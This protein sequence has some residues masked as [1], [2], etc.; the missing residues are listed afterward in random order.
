MNIRKFT[1]VGAGTMGHGI[2]EL[3]ALAGYEVWLNDVNDDILKNALERIKWSLNKLHEKGQIKGVDEVIS[4]IRITSNLAEAVKDTDFLVEAVL[5][6]INVKREIFSK[7]DE[8]ASKDAV[9]ATNTSSLP[10][11]E[12]A[13]STK[14]PGRVLG[15]HFFNPPVLM[16]LVEVIRG[17]YT[18]DKVV[19]EAISIVERMGKT[20]II[21][22]K[23]IP[24][25][26]V[27]RLLFRLF[28]ISCLLVEGGK[29]SITDVD[30]TAIYELGF[31]MGV[32]ILEDYTGIDIGYLVGKAMIERG[33]KA[34]E[35]RMLEEKFS[36]REF[37][38]KSGK[39]FYSYPQPGKFVVPEIPK[40]SKVNGLTLI[41]PVINEASYLLRENISSKEDIDKGCKLGLGW[42]RGIFEYA[43]EYGIDKV[44]ATLDYLYNETNM[45]QFKP[46]P[47]L[48]EMMKTGKLG[49]KTGEGFYKYGE[50][51]T[52]G[53]LTIRVEEPLGWIILDKRDGINT[54]DRELISDLSKA[55]DIMEDD[56]RVRVIL[57][58]GNG[59]AFSVGVDVKEFLNLTPF[60]AM[61]ASRRLQELFNKIQFLAKPVIAVIHGYALGG[62]L[63]LAM[64]CD[65]RVAS[66]DAHLGQPEINLGLIPGAGGS[67]RLPRLAKNKG[68]YLV[69][70]GEIIEAEEAFRVGLVDF[71]AEPEKLEDEA[72]KIALKL[73]EKSPLAL[74]S[75]KYAINFGLQGNIWVG[76]A[77]ESSLFGLLFSTKDV[78]E[79]VTAFLNKR[80]PRFKGE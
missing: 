69:L 57:I 56:D 72:K 37:G 79:G 52:V 70:S 2:A 3:A 48:L 77:Y 33:V 54:L 66:R 75:A 45:E 68:T 15:I 35:C 34:Y 42:S 32:F 6:D 28:E 26:I 80:K 58:K 19:K 74:A 9:L 17:K 4:R 46:D 24:G 59:R 63:E 18:E 11:T 61:I 50:E 10:I 47:L 71:I 1:V 51:K 12:I 16:P 36:K 39:G 64:S 40:T 43:D 62:G 73:A 53:S 44:V 14:N 31:P 38:V 49:K 8:L 29:A 22:N 78:Q 67:Q 60:K 23:D 41:S 7:A 25:F 27:N 13:S 5:E 21:V 76:E 20:P 65:I 55:L 30:S